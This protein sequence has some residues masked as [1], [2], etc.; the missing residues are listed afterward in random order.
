LNGLYADCTTDDAAK[1]VDRLG[2][3]QI[4]TLRGVVTQAAWHDI[5][6][7]YVVCTEDRAVGPGLQRVLA[8]R[9]TR[10][11]EWPTSHSP[12]LS[13]PELVANLLIE[14]AGH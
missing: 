8:R 1:A 6:S 9:C 13:R 14:L 3:Q 5:P 2:P 10:T 4:A 11:I 12:F 7:T